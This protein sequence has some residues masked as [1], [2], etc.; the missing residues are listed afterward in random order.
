MDLAIWKERK[1]INEA[2]FITFFGIRENLSMINVEL[3]V[4]ELVFVPQIYLD[5]R[6]LLKYGHEDKQHFK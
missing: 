6:F 3:V 2:T 1:K 5:G 4:L